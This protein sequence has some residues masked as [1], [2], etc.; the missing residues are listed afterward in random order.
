MQIKFMDT[1]RKVPGATS[2]PSLLLAEDD[3]DQSDM[4][5]EILEDE[6]YRVDAVFSGD[7]A[8]RNLKR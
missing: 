3:P 6:G 7:M 2:Q 8:L 1:N 5:R 4:L